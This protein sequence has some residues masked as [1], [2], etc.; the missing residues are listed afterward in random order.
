MASMYDAI[1]N[2]SHQ[3]PD[4]SVIMHFSASF[5]IVK[6]LEERTNE[7]LGNVVTGTWKTNDNV[8]L[9]QYTTNCSMI[10]AR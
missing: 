7:I 3:V 4:Q 1:G 6:E 5:D 8:G 9:L 2:K 10:K